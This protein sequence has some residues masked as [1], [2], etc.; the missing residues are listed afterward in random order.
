MGKNYKIHYEFEI[1][2]NK[3]NYEDGIIQYWKSRNFEFE[4]KSDSYNGKRGSIIG[5]LFSFDMSKLISDLK[6]VVKEN[7]KI[8]TDLILNTQFQD[9]TEVNLWDLKLELIMFQRFINDLPQ[10]DFLDDFIKFKNKSA[11]LWTFTITAAGR[12]ISQDL[13]EKL[14]SLCDGENLPIVEIL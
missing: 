7:K 10:P 8:I 9:I 1:K 13:K 5:N 2:S 3:K 12:N 11:I 6:I 4:D 14:E